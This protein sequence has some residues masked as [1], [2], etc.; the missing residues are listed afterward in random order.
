MPFIK[1]V[2]VGFAE[3]AVAAASLVGLSARANLP[4]QEHL[5]FHCFKVIAA[6]IDDLSIYPPDLRSLVLGILKR[7][8]ADFFENRAKQS[9]REHPAECSDKFPDEKTD[10]ILKVHYFYVTLKREASDLYSA[11][12]VRRG[13]SGRFLPRKPRRGLKHW[14][15]YSVNQARS[16][17]W[18]GEPERFSA[19]RATFSNVLQKLRDAMQLTVKAPYG[20]P[21]ASSLSVYKGRLDKNNTPVSSAIIDGKFADPLKIYGGSRDATRQENP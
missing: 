9:F 8:Y 3:L 19:Y 4:V 6:V 20:H 1:R 16:R 18:I 17:W 10:R 11:V 5:A 2:I 12:I 21:P 13:V 7:N 15:E 14:E